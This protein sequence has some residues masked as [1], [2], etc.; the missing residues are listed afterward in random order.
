MSFVRKVT[1]INV[2][3]VQ[4][5]IGAHP[6]AYYLVTT[7]NWSVTVVKWKGNNVQEMGVYQDLLC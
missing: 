3:E 7:T 1:K 2:F 4:I 5:I 6:K